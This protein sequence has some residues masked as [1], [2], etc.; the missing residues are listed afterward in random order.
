MYIKE[1]PKILQRADI[2]EHRFVEL[3][4]LCRQYEDYVTG[5]RGERGKERAR[6][7]LEVVQRVAGEHWRLMLEHISTGAPCTQLS[8]PLPFGVARWA[9]LRLVFFIELNEELWYNNNDRL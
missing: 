4:A 8:A 7:I 3:V 9:R 2:S 1:F 6:V 5:K